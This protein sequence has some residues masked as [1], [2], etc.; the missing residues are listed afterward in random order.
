MERASLG[1]DKLTAL[2]IINQIGGPGQPPS[3]GIEFFS[4]GLEK[5]LSVLDKEYF[6]GYIKDGGSAFKMVVGVYGGGKT[7]FLY[8]LRD[9]AW[10]HNFVVSYVSLKASGECPF[11]QFDLVYKAIISGLVPPKSQTELDTGYQEGI[12]TFLETWYRQRVEAYRSQKLPEEKIHSEIREELRQLKTSS[13]SFAHAIKSALIAHMNG[14]HPTFD[15]MCQW[16]KGEGFD[17]KVLS[18][19]QILQKIDKSTAFQMI[20]SLGQSIKCLGYSG[21]IILLDEAERIPG[22]SSKQR[23]QHLGN[24][25]EIIDECGQPT[26]NSMMLFYAVPDANFLDGRTMVYDA[27][28]QR[29]GTTFQTHNPAG[30]K[31][32]LEHIISEPISFLN[33]V[34]HK[35]VEVYEVA[36]SCTLNLSDWQALIKDFADKAYDERFGDEGYKRLFVQK[37]VQGLQ[38]LK[39]E[40]RISSWSELSR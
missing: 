2:S 35:I 23:E 36:Y 27:L 12:S 25:R 21:L 32:E 19:H 20:R 22:L 13:I 39:H 38:I 10:Q 15:I 24:L 26:F 11:H 34:G 40:S 7:H 30:V 17:R 33:E 18:K 4:V 3:H 14:D 1:L 16:L 6:S 9:L 31:I 37:L 5:C 29:V 28:K 8:S